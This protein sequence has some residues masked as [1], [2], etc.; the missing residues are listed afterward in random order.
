MKQIVSF[1]KLKLTNN[2]LDDN[3]HVSDTLPRLRA[4]LGAGPGELVGQSQR[5]GWISSGCGGGTGWGSWWGGA[6][7]GPGRRVTLLP[8]PHSWALAGGF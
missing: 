1:D 8:L 6:V 7:L 3:G 2:L 5:Q 4:V